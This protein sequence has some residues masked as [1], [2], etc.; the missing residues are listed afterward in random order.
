MACQY[1]ARFQIIH[2]DIKPSN[3]LIQNGMHKLCDFGFSC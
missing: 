2:R 3:V 1:L